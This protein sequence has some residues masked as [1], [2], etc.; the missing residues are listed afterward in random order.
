MN[1]IKMAAVVLVVGGFLGLLY[2]GFSYTRETQQAKLGPI[3]LSI[4][5][6]QTVRVPIWVSVGAL[7]AGGG[8]FI[9]ATKKS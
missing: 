9:L 4:E 5:D 1:A 2:G 7:L 6:R 8:L 3:E